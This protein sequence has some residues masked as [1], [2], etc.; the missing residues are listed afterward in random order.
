MR[1]PTSL[2]VFPVNE[3]A[4]WQAGEFKRRRRRSHAGIGVGDY[5]IAGAAEVEG[6]ELATLNVKHV[7]MFAGLDPPFEIRS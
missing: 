5:L 4:C 6:L 1:L 2:D 7:P 3:R